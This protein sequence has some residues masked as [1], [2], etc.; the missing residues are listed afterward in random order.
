MASLV[1]AYNLCIHSFTIN[2]KTNIIKCNKCD[3]QF[4]IKDC[5]HKY[6]TYIEKL[7]PGHLTYGSP[8]KYCKICNVE[9]EN[10]SGIKLHNYRQSIL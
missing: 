6:G 1:E 7:S 10:I 2:K 3:E 8:P 4:N 5:E 9:L